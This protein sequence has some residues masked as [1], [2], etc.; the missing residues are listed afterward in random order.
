MQQ[1]DNDLNFVCK[2][3]YKVKLWNSA[4]NN[5]M[6]ACKENKQHLCFCYELAPRYFVTSGKRGECAIPQFIWCAC[7]HTRFACTEDRKHLCYRDL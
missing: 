5:T 3:T 4:C 1:L 6:F 2:I 7:Y